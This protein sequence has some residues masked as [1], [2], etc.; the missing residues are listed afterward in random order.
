MDSVGKIN[1]YIR[2][3]INHLETMYKHA[4]PCPICGRK[5]L[6]ISYILDEWL[7]SYPRYPDLDL[8]E[9]AMI[10]SNVVAKFNCPD[11]VTVFE[12]HHISYVFNITMD[13]CKD[14]HRKIH[15]S[16]VDP[17]CRF[18]PWDSPGD[19]KYYEK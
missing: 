12:H 15:H 10:H 17:Y 19:K 7:S 2:A 3:G 8:K 18:K 11:D 14:C 5:N 1:R 16:D 13:L 6:S 9:K 4:R